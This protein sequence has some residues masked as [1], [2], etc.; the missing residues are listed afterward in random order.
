M[1]ED[2]KED[3]NEV[4][5]PNTSGVGPLPRMILARE[6]GLLGR[7]SA[8]RPVGFRPAGSN[9][10]RALT[11]DEVAEERLITQPRDYETLQCKLV[12][13]TRSTFLMVFSPDK[14]LLAS[15]HG[16]HNIYITKVRNIFIH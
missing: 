3:E 5:T 1:E 13:P 11:A 4:F 7:P 8:R 12:G 15:T 6:Y 16:D 2:L 10:Q 14:E 9:P